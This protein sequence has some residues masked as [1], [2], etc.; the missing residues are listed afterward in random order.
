MKI[1]SEYFSRT[2]RLKS[3]GYFFQTAWV[4]SVGSK[5]L[6]KMGEDRPMTFGVYH[7]SQVHVWRFCT[8]GTIE[9]CQGEAGQ[10]EKGICLLIYTVRVFLVATYSGIPN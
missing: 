10:L 3:L 2:L 4:N 8:L 9:D 5:K 6:A 1:K 7:G